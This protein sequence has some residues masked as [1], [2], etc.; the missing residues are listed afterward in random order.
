MGCRC[1]D[2]TVEG[3]KARAERDRRIKDVLDKLT[4][5]QRAKIDEGQRRLQTFRR[6]HGDPF[7][8]RGLTR[9]AV[10]S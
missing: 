4:P 10:T 8:R 3:M 7:R 2:D 9:S 5:D 6:E 1:H